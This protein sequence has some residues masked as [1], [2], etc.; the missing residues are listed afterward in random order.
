LKG[1]TAYPKVS[2]DNLR[3][4]SAKGGYILVIELNTKKEIHPGSLGAIPF[5][6]GFYAY[7]G[8]ALGGF[9]SRINR[10]LCKD[11]K[12]KWHIDYLL[13]EG[14][15]LQVILCKTARRLECL[16]SQA[17]A[18]EFSSIPSFGS[19]DCKCKSHLYFSADRANLEIGIKKVIAEVALPQEYFQ[20][21]TGC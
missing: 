11:K 7:L 18:D 13:N 15:V 19:N 3:A 6:K 5:S 12:L 8:T 21:I 16:L 9:S 10:H 17:M 14:G 20:E 1:S 2:P 4:K